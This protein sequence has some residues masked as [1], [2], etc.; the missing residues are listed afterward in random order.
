VVQGASA[1]DERGQTVEPAS[2]LARSWSASGA[3][4]RVW[5]RSDSDP[6]AALDAYE[7]A[8][9]ALAAAVAGVPQEWNDETD[10][11]L[12]VVAADLADGHP[13]YL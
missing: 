3:L 10:R 9:L 1:R 13:I 12:V 11:T 2:A 5:R 8:H 7:A 4:E 6:N